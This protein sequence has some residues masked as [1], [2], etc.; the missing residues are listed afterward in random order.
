M[1]YLLDTNILSE[2]IK[3]RKNAGVLDWLAA[4]ST[5]EHH[6]SVLSIGEIRRGISLLQIR[7]D[8]AQAGRYEAWL[9]GTIAEF[10]DRIVP[11][12][13]GIAQRWGHSDA[14]RPMPT[15]D[16]LIGA[17]AALHDM[18]LVTRNVKDFQPLGIRLLNPFTA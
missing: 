4:T 3:R 5:L 16:A 17:T 12:D 8:H 11:L 18:T 6:I 1:T 9:E 15:A 13:I 7:H 2:L 10:T 14:V